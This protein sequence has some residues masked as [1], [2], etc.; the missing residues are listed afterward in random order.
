MT[1][2][3][4]ALGLGAA[5]IAVVVAYYVV[6]RVWFRPR[7]RALR[8]ERD[9]VGYRVPFALLALYFVGLVGAPVT[10]AFIAYWRLISHLRGG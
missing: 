2:W 7:V 5:S 1:E 4:V 6:W 3:A 10:A 8:I 9:L